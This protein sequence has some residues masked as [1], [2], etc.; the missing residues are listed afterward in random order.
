MRAEGSGG[1]GGGGLD[2][3]RLLDGLLSGSEIP[4]GLRMRRCASRSCRRWF[5]SRQSGDDYCS[6]QC[7][8]DDE[9]DKDR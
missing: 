7:D 9:R 4:A 2:D 6:A 5:A 3:E 1:R 8:R